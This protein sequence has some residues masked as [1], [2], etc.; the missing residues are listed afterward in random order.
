MSAPVKGSLWLRRSCYRIEDGEFRA[1]VERVSSV[2]SIG[3]ERFVYMVQT[4]VPPIGRPYSVRYTI[5]EFHQLYIGLP[6]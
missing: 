5:D 2:R 6:A 3:D 4:W 1:C